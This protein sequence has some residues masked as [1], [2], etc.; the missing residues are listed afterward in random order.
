MSRNHLAFMFAISQSNAQLSVITVFAANA[1]TS[2]SQSVLSL[3]STTMTGFP[4]GVAE[5][6]RGFHPA[7]PPGALGGAAHSQ[8]Q[9]GAGEGA[10]IRS[11]HA[12]KRDE[13]ARR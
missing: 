3:S 8:P 4:E 7:S 11:P 5:Q 9:P 6:G 13:S 12:R 2:T 10:R 1:P